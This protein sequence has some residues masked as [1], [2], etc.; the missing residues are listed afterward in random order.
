MDSAC[1]PSRSFTVQGFGLRDWWACSDGGPSQCPWHQGLVGQGEVCSSGSASCMP[2]NN[3]TLL[4]ECPELLLKTC[5]IVELLTFVLSG[6]PFTASSCPFP[7]FTLQTPLYST[8][9]PPY[10]ETHNSGRGAEGYSPDHVW[11]VLTFSC[12]SHIGCCVPLWSSEG[13][14]LPLL[15]FPQQMDFSEYENLS[16]SA[17][18]QR[19]WSLPVF[20]FF[21][22]SHPTWLCGDFSCPFWCLRFSANFQQVLCDSC[23]ICRYILNILVRR[24]KF[25]I[26]QFHHL[27]ASLQQQHS[28]ED[29]RAQGRR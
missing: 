15:I 27:N 10:Q 22:F 23:S 17:P 19:C 12:L 26:L 9:P 4:L 28:D 1:G 13:P 3:G 24:G 29:P 11:T 5:L 8:Q 16:P 20:S 14:F 7:G 21:S 18:F 2:L 6:C 25:F